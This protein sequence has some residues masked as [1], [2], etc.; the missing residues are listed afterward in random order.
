MHNVYI[1]DGAFYRLGDG[2]D[3]DYYGCFTSG[4]PISFQYT[5]PSDNTTWDITVYPIG[6][7]ERYPGRTYYVSRPENDGEI[8]YILWDAPNEEYGTTEW[9]PAGELFQLHIKKYGKDATVLNSIF[10]GVTYDG[11]KVAYNSVREPYSVGDYYGESGETWDEHYSACTEYCQV[12]N[13]SGAY[14]SQTVDGTDD[15]TLVNIE[16][17]VVRVPK[18]T[19]RVRPYYEY[20]PER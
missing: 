1:K 10:P 3:P 5:D 14:V 2:S 19:K 7:E 9:S 13:C 11:E 18:G 20:S 16:N 12:G 6:D 17:G 15:W 4:D 8:R